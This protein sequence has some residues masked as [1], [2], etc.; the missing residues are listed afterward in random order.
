MI[1]RNINLIK[2]YDHQSNLMLED[3]NEES[4]LKDKLSR[5]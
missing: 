2:Q 1:A 5:G 3:N 4:V